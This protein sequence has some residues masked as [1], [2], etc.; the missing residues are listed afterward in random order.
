[1]LEVHG[2]L[3]SV[4][5]QTL[6]RNKD[7]LIDIFE[8]AN[9]SGARRDTS[10]GQTSFID[11]LSTSPS[12]Q[13]LSCFAVLGQTHD[14]RSPPRHSRFPRYICFSLVRLNGLLTLN[15]VGE[16]QRSKDGGVFWSLGR[17]ACHIDEVVREARIEVIALFNLLDILRTELQAQSLYIG[18]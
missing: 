10:L 8:R 4:D 12:L 15:I 18:L 2:W 16:A 13:S 7:N 3:K 1:M 11:S 14:L 6:T 17:F 9:D 5:C